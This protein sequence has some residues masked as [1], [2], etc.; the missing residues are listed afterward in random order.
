MRAKDPDDVQLFEL[1]SEPASGGAQALQHRD[2]CCDAGVVRQSDEAHALRQCVRRPAGLRMQAAEQNELVDP[3]RQSR[4]K[5]DERAVSGET[6][7]VGSVDKI[8]VDSESHGREAAQ[9]CSEAAAA[10]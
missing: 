7:V 8:C 10:G 5:E 9:S 2:D 1:G 4:E 3:L 6:V